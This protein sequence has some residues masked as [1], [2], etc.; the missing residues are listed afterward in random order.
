LHRVAIFGTK[1]LFDVG[2]EADGLAG[3]GLLWHRNSSFLLRREARTRLFPVSVSPSGRLVASVKD[4]GRYPGP[5]A[6]C[7]RPRRPGQ[8]HRPDHVADM[9]PVTHVG[10]VR[11]CD[12][13]SAGGPVESLNL[14]DPPR[15]GPGQVLLSVQAAGV[16]PWDALLHTGGWDVGCDH[17]PRSA[18]RAREW[19]LPGTTT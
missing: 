13:R 4:P 16:G 14:Q 2:L 12:V 5:P 9:G 7:G 10:L 17:Q 1:Q 6:G 19:W 18:S 8:F 11:A 15:P 3:R